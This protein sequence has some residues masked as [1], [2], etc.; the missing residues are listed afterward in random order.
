MSVQSASIEN[1]MKGQRVVSCGRYGLDFQSAA[2][3]GSPKWEC[4]LCDCIQDWHVE[5]MG[6]PVRKQTKEDWK[7][8]VC[9]EAGNKSQNVVV[10]NHIQK[11][12]DMNFLVHGGGDGSVALCWLRSPFV[13]ECK[14]A[15]PNIRANR[16]DCVIVLCKSKRSE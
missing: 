11:S 4:A 13:F 12:I 8:R 14:P 3:Q 7:V 10:R 9:K 5:Q 6:V 16:H 15:L 2:I 1:S